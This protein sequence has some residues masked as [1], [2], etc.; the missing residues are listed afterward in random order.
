MRQQKIEKDYWV[1]LNPPLC[2]SDKDVDI[3]K[4]HLIPGTTLLLGCTK[5]LIHLSDTQMDLEPFDFIP[6]PIVQDWVTNTDPYTNIIGDGVF[7]FTKEL[8]DGV[9]EMASKNCKKLIVRSFNRKMDIMRIADNFPTIEDF[10][11]KPT[12]VHRFDDYTFYVWDF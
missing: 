5:Q 10:K 3:F 4:S 6:N 1:S 7:N 11:I 12:L 9:L 8:C 2:P